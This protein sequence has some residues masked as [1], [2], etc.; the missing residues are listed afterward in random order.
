MQL[1]S[2]IN[3]STTLTDAEVLAALPDLQMQVS[4]HFGPVWAAD[5]QL[6]FCPRSGAGPVAGSWWLVILDDADQAMAVGYH[7][8]TAE[9]LPLGKVFARTDRESG[10]TWTVTAS[11]ELLEMLADP[12]MDRATVFSDGADFRVYAYEV[13]D[14][15]EDDGFGY[16][17]NG[18]R[19]SDFVLPEW[20]NPKSPLSKFDFC[21]HVTRP[22][23]L[24][25]GG[26]I[27]V[28]DPKSGWTQQQQ[29]NVAK[30][31]TGKLKVPRGADT[32]F[33]GRRERRIRKAA[34][35]SMIRSVRTSDRVDAPG[36]STGEV[37]VLTTLF[38]LAAIGR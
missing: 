34:G 28:F 29:P 16:Q 22:L 18:T 25:P 21:G 8:L 19:V 20:F 6:Q 30:Q 2:V 12:W 10:H 11:H 7:D 1:I 4:A 38:I 27:G 26:Y 13:C 33:G 35:A 9:G 14:A 36:W 5:A 37:S 17:I 15:C 32:K 31:F 3:A 24:L 23:Q